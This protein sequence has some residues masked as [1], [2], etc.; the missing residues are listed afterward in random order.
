M[1]DADAVHLDPSMQRSP[2]RGR[3]ESTEVYDRSAQRDDTEASDQK[4]SA[5]SPD[6]GT[7]RTHRRAIKSVLVL[8]RFLVAVRHGALDGEEFFPTL[9]EMATLPHGVLPPE[10]NLKTRSCIYLPPSREI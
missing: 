3:S 6:K 7:H 4:S 5:I 2:V 9:F 1:G 8:G 10:V